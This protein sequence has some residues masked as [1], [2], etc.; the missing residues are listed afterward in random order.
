MALRLWQVTFFIHTHRAPTSAP[1]PALST[2][3]I[4]LHESLHGQGYENK[5]TRALAFGG[6]WMAIGYKM[7]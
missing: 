1:S 5:V 3:A 2:W 6:E 7:Q 4:A